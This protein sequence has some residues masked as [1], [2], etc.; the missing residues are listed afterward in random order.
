VTEAS[1]NTCLR[2]PDVETRLGCGKCG[3]PICP[4]CLVHTSVGA[5]CPNCAQVKKSVVYQVSGALLYRSI[6]AAAV[7]G[8]VG[9]VILGILAGGGLA[10]GLFLVVALFA[11]MG[12]AGQGTANHRFGRYHRRDGSRVSVL[13]VCNRLVD[14]GH[15]R[16]I[17][18]RTGQGAVE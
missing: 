8:V 10:R 1:A 2:H 13:G 9:G 5:R 14:S 4:R 6:A 16:R 18:G 7:V 17:C 11:A 12:Y 15:R 3:D